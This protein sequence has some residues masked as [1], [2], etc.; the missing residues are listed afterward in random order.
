MKN[1]YIIWWL[2]AS[3]ATITLWWVW[4]QAVNISTTDFDFT[5]PS[6]K[7]IFFKSLGDESFSTGVAL[8]GTGV[9]V[10]D[11]AITG[12]PWASVLKLDSS[13]G[14]SSSSAKD[15][16][17]KLV[18][19]SNDIATGALSS[20][21]FD[22]SIVFLSGANLYKTNTVCA[23]W[24]AIVAVTTGAL[25][26]TTYITCAT[27]WWAG[28]GGWAWLNCTQDWDFP[29]RFGTW[30]I[31]GSTWLL[32]WW[33]WSWD[34]HWTWYTRGNINNQNLTWKVAVWLTTPTDTL[35]TRENFLVQNEK[36]NAQIWCHALSGYVSMATYKP[37]NCAVCDD[38]TYAF[39]PASWQCKKVM[40]NKVDWI[41][42]TP[43]H[44]WTYLT[45]PLWPYCAWGTPTALITTA[46]WWTWSCLGSW[47]WHNAS[48]V[49]YFWSTPSPIDGVCGP[50]ALT[51]SATMPTDPGLCN[52]GTTWAVTSIGSWSRTWMCNGLYG[53]TGASCTTPSS[54][55]DYSC[56]QW[57]VLTWDTDVPADGTP[58]CIAGIS[59]GAANG[60]IV[61]GAAA[62]NAAWLCY[63]WDVA[64]VS[65]VFWSGPRNWDCY[66]TGTNMTV[67]CS[68]TSIHWVCGPADGNTAINAA[69]I[70]SVGLCNVWTPIVWWV[71]W[72]TA[73]TDPGPWDWECVWLSGVPVA[74]HSEPDACRQ[75]PPAWWS[76]FDCNTWIPWMT[77]MAWIPVGQTWW[78]VC[79]C[80]GA[81]YSN[82]CFAAQAWLKT[83]TNWV[84][85]APSDLWY[86][87]DGIFQ[88][89][90]GSQFFE[91]CDAWFALNGSPW[92]YCS[93]SCT[94]QTS[95][96]CSGTWY[97]YKEIVIWDQF[98]PLWGLDNFN[99]LVKIQAAYLP[100][101]S[102]RNFVSTFMSGSQNLG[103][104]DTDNDDDYYL[105][106]TRL[107]TPPTW[108]T[109]R[110]VWLEIKT[111]ES[112]PALNTD[113]LL[114]NIRSTPVPWV[115]SWTPL[116]R[117]QMMSQFSWSCAIDSNAFAPYV[118]SWLPFWLTLWACSP[119]FVSALTGGAS[120][121]Y[122]WW[123]DDHNADWVKIKFGYK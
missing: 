18:N 30:W 81:T 59:C 14:G 65:A 95:I 24:D 98:N 96:W 10:S 70:L 101:L 64:S 29:A 41:C 102:Y 60:L 36:M 75:E 32:L 89:P 86:C 88:S 116:D 55:I 83:W 82:A 40:C 34:P 87:W 7:A 63:P 93:A 51:W 15:V 21:N 99:P 92:F 8:D 91:Q 9:Y 56:P 104:F 3:L 1:K 22:P 54:C 13:F 73:L 26:E 117:P 16:V 69:E 66:N 78:S 23:P 77:W 38:P 74:C 57:Y 120:Y 58:N 79:A 80:D 62:V 76:W 114:L 68:A 112:G 44:L 33:S 39:D 71:T 67:S 106:N 53:W 108:K 122:L 84:C 48:C 17:E 25:P 27:M 115:F 43:P 105:A 97:V 103:N 47:S 5:I 50:D 118:W 35:H 12:D 4:V 6:F 20:G 2:V 61:S 19:W 110:C 113:A 94:L 31:C 90:N 42:A 85:E 121:L 11:S 28:S 119:S 37:S 72:S 109:L 100:T 46:T 52:A 49:A 111:K 45:M 107:P 123:N